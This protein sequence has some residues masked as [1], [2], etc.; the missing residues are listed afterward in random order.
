MKFNIGDRII[1]CN[2]EDQLL[3]GLTGVIDG[4]YDK[5]TSDYSIT[6]DYKQI[7]NGKLDLQES[8]LK[9]IEE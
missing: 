6:L 9:L 1:T 8:N 7:L 2:S 5:H 3:N 4:V